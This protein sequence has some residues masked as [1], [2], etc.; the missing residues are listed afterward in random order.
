MTTEDVAARLGALVAYRCAATN[1]RTGR[2]CRT[3]LLEA[4]APMGALVRRRCKECGTW[5]VVWIEPDRSE[6]P[7][8]LLD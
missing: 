8:A 7:P 1:P 4:W 6:E 2:P 5:S 3:V